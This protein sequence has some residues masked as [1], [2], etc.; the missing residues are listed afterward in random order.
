MEKRLHEAKLS[1]T[2]F[3]P[4]VNGIHL[5]PRVDGKA[6]EGAVDRRSKAGP[7]HLPCNPLELRTLGVTC[8]QGAPDLVVK[9]TRLLAVDL[10][11]TAFPTHSQFSVHSCKTA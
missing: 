7:T 6:R 9:L 2:R 8:R 4:A 5:Q 10:I 1:G 3:N 11:L